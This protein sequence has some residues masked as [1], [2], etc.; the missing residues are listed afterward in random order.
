MPEERENQK[1]PALVT[2][3]NTRQRKTP[4]T[5]RDNGSQPVWL[6]SGASLCI[7]VAAVRYEYKRRG[8][9]TRTLWHWQAR[10]GFRPPD[11]AKIKAVGLTVARPTAKPRERKRHSRPGIKPSANR[12][13][14]WGAV[15]DHCLETSRSVF[16]D[17]S[18]HACNSGTYSRPDDTHSL[19]DAEVM[20][21]I[22][23]K[24]AWLPA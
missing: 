11:S 14:G 13:V 9:G 21:K 16:T 12:V 19:T 3:G 6:S 7:F 8:G 10:P 18:F 1:S 20:D 2:P 24:F 4:D 15:V 5:R 22:L 17:A 23:A